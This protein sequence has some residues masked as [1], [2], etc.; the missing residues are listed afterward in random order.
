[1]NQET[2][3]TIDIGNQHSCVGIFTGDELATVGPISDISLP[4]DETCIIY[5]SVGKKNKLPGQ[6]ASDFFTNGHFLNMPIRYTQELGIDRAVLSYYFFKGVQ[7]PPTLIIDSG[8]FMTLDFIT[9]EGFM[10]GLILPGVDL[11]LNT[12]T[13]AARIP[14]ISKEDIPIKPSPFSLGNCTHTSITSGLTAF[15]EGVLKEMLTVYKPKNI[16]LT[17]GTGK[18]LQQFLPKAEFHPHFIHLSLRRILQ[19]KREK[20]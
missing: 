2:I 20:R 6:N 12:F 4:T 15:I 8:T 13:K 11:Y 17:G 9:S 19:I 5:S 14:K 18:L 10:G 7:T 1:M 16:Y 3:Y